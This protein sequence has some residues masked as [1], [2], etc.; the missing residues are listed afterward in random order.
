MFRAWLAIA[1]ALPG[2]ATAEAADSQFADALVRLDAKP[3][4]EII[5]EGP[6]MTFRKEITSLTIEIAREQRVGIDRQAAEELDKLFTEA[7]KTFELEQEKSPDRNLLA[8]NG[9]RFVARLI[10][11]AKPLPSEKSELLAVIT[12]ESVER[13]RTEI[14]E[15]I[16]GFCPCWPFCR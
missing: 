13:L 8:A 15:R 11:L 2:Y 16:S 6:A 12:G 7:G 5:S 3:L 10:S 14:K 4:Q 1:I 9:L